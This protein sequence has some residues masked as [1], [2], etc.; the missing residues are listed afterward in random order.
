MS[1]IDPAME[2]AFYPEAKEATNPLTVED[3]RHAVAEWIRIYWDKYGHGP[4]SADADH[5]ALLFRL[6][7][8]KK[9]LPVAPPT[10]FSYPNYTLGEGRPYE[11]FESHVTKDGT[12][13]I[14]QSLWR[15]ES[16]GTLVWPE[17]GERYR[18]QSLGV[19]V[20]ASPSQAA[21]G[22]GD[23]CLSR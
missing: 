4:S 23:A 15:Q 9:A 20:K 2:K 21:D 13:V 16:D 5:S 11:V 3:C 6:L 12:V 7:S 17:T 19:L 1:R 10:T 14:D 8:G 22:G 18:W